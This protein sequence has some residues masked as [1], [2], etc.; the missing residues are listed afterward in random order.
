[1]DSVSSVSASSSSSNETVSSLSPT[2][3]STLARS[4][5]TTAG[6]IPASTRVNSLEALR[7]ESPKVYQQFMMTIANTILSDIRQQQEHLKKAMRE[8]RQS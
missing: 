4:K 7:S 1:M 5:A 2:D 6:E 3:S 8:A